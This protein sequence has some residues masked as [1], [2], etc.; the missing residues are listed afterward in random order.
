[1][2]ALEGN[3]NDVRTYRERVGGRN[4]GPRT[5]D[6]AVGRTGAAARASVVIRDRV[7]LPRADKCKYLKGTRAISELTKGM[8]K[9]GT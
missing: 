1:M 8:P 4:L 5:I 3:M 9:F 7:I 2:S 6:D